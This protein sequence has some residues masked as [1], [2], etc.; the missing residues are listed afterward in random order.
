LTT[1]ANSLAATYIGTNWVISANADGRIYYANDSLPATWTASTVGNTT[2]RKNDFAVSGSNALAV[3]YKIVSGSERYYA[4][5][6]TAVAT[7]TT[8][9]NSLDTT[10]FFQLYGC[11]TNG[12]G[13]W[14]AVG[15]RNTAQLSYQT[16]LGGTWTTGTIGVVSYGISFGT[17]TWVAGGNSGSLYSSTNLSTWTSRTSQ[18]G[19]SQIRQI[20]FGNSLFV[21]VGADGKIS[22]SSDGTTWTAR[23]S[24]TTQQLEDVRWCNPLALWI[25][26]GASGT[27]LTSPDAITWTTRSAPGGVG[28]ALYRVAVKP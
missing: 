22:T 15:D 12:S 8:N 2:G 5:Q 11:A 26:C 4:E 23:T 6:S 20:R 21:A 27:I 10:A 19:T 13:T 14:A 17:S 18:F 28:S 9:E 24:G 7:W 25:A 16:S 1:P 3:G